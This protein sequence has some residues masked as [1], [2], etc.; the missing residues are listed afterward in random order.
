MPSHETIKAPFSFVKTITWLALGI[1]IGTTGFFIVHYSIETVNKDETDVI[2]KS[3]GKESSAVSQDSS[4]VPA[5]NFVKQ[6]TDP[7]LHHNTVQRFRTVYSYVASVAEED[8]IDTLKRA[9]DNRWIKSARVQEALQT[10][11]L[12]RLVV[13]T[14]E[15]ALEIALEPQNRLRSKLIKTVFVEWA[16]VDLDASL[17]QVRHLDE[18]LRII[19][20]MSIIET[21][22]EQPLS[23]IQEIGRALDLESRAVSHYIASLNTEHVKE[24]KNRWYELVSVQEAT[25]TSG[26]ELASRIAYVWYQQEGLNVLDEI[27]ESE[28]EDRFKGDAINRILESITR[29]DPTGA[30][31]YAQ[32]IPQEGVFQMFPPTIRV[33]SVWAETYPLA[34]L[35]AIKI[36]EPNGLRER[37]QSSAVNS[38][39]STNPREVLENLETVPKSTQMSAVSRAFSSLAQTS[40]NEGSSLVLQL[41]DPAIRA[42]AAEALIYRWS[43]DDVDSSLDWVLKYPETEP[44]RE[45]LV[46]TVLSVM[47]DSDPKRAVQIAKEQPI[48]KGRELGLEAQLVSALAFRDV[49]TAIDLLPEVRDGKTKSAV[50]RSV[51]VS[52]VANG[53]PQKALS[54]V[55]Q[56][57]DTAKARFYRSIAYEWAKFDPPAVL[58]ALEEFPTAEIRSEVARELSRLHTQN[59]SDSEMEALKQYIIENENDV[60]EQ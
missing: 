44:V 51:G 36:V 9:T 39:A 34:A 28:T 18:S 46:A 59:F 60:S 52:L 41:K 17:E 31:Q 55:Q 29:E 19:A 45:Q 4:R 38:W 23:R 35:E 56:L 12:E 24:P 15:A 25:D 14:P 33:V 37:L 42:R 22:L 40:P 11:L 5:D 20:L 27:L 2:P 43:Q 10:A 58:T 47:V 1:G 8:L 30:F 32:N 50:Y 53:E 6:L 13:S 26:Y 48:A 57:P 54:L 16:N 7:S 49:D 21:L 3:V